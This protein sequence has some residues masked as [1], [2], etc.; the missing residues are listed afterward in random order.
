M[1]TFEVGCRVYQMA[2]LIRLSEVLNRNYFN[3]LT[4]K[5]EMSQA[6]KPLAPGRREG[7]PFQNL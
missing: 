1:G 2:T 6:L 5:H 7:G 3:Q 4:H